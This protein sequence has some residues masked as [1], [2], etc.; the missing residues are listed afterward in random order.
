M[1][2]LEL[3]PLY[4]VYPIYLNKDLDL[5]ILIHHDKYPILF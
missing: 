4:M 5:E 2:K 1:D 3:D